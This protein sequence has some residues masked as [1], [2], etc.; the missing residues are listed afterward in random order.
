VMRAGA[1]TTLKV[2]SASEERAG[3][4]MTRS[5]TGPSL[6]GRLRLP[7]P[8][9]GTAD[10]DRERTLA[11]TGTHSLVGSGQVP[12]ARRGLGVF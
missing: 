11:K 5:F 1:Q 2:S 3:P 4:W 6:E 9:G 8:A 12:A 10:L 7:D